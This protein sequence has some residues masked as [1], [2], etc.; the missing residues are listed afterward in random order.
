MRSG[1]QFSKKYFFM[2]KKQGLIFHGKLWNSSISLKLGEIHQISPNSMEFG[3]FHGI[4]PFLVNYR[5]FGA[6][7]QNAF[8]TNGKSMISGA[9]SREITKF[10]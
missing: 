10:W 7:P 1:A 6:P 9:I 8:K 4:S 5:T 3:E 2:P